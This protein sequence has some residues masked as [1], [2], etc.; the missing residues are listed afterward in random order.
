MDFIIQTLATDKGQTC[1]AILDALPHWFGLEDAKGRYVRGVEESV[2]LI[3]R[4]AISSEVVGF[5]SLKERT[6]ATSEIYVMG[7]RPEFHRHGLGR[8]L[9]GEAE[10]LAFESGKIFLSVKTLSPGNPD[11]HYAITRKFYQALGFNP[12]EVFPTLWGKDN[13]CLLMIKGLNGLV[14]ATKS[15]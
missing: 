6:E 8:K 4:E 12:I 2:F 11:P 15:R 5:I 9:V 1:K 3:C 10:K 7:I 14:R 13:P